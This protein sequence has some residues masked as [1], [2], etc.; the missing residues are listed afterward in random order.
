[1]EDVLLGGDREGWAAFAVDGA[2]HQLIAPAALFQVD[3]VV[4][5]DR[6]QW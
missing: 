6:R 2:E 4:G 3:A 5:E 1:M